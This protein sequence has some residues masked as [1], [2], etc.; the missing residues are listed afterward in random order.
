MKSIRTLCVIV[1]SCVL[2]VGIIGLIIPFDFENFYYKDVSK[3]GQSHSSIVNINIY[4]KS[5]TRYN[6]VIIKIKYSAKKSF[7]SSESHT[8][9]IDHQNL[10]E[11]HNSVVFTHSST[12][13]STFDKINSIELTLDNGRTFKIYEHNSIFSGIN[14]LFLC[15]CLFGFFGLVAC[16]AVYA[17]LKKMATFADA[18]IKNFTKKIQEVF[19]PIIKQKSEEETYSTTNTK[20]K[21]VTCSYCKSKYDSHEDKCPHCGAPPEP[22][23]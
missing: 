3:L 18:K 14:F 21:K 15:F 20:V 7:S 11:E 6:D 13:S 22:C 8:I 5:H 17:Y 1:C 12:S 19:T 10:K 2:L 16:F 4:N 23:D 9:I